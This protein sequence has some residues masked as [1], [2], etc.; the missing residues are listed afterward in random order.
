MYPFTAS[1]ELPSTRRRHVPSSSETSMC[2]GAGLRR[3]C[4]FGSS[5]SASTSGVPACVAPHGITSAISEMN[6]RTVAYRSSSCLRQAVSASSSVL[7]GSSSPSSTIALA[8][9]SRVTSC[10]IRSHAWATLSGTGSPPPSPP[11]LS[12]GT[13]RNTETASLTF[14]AAFR[15]RGS[16]FSFALS[17]SRSARASS[18]VAINVSNSVNA[19]STE[20]PSRCRIVA[21]TVAVRRGS[22]S[23]R[24]VGACALIPYRASSASFT[25]GTRHKSSSPDF[26]PWTSRVRS[27]AAFCPRPDTSRGPLRHPSST[28]RAAP[29]GTSRSSSSPRRNSGSTG[30]STTE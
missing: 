17:S 11:S 5:R 21:S 23:L 26:T 2:S 9:S 1:S 3:A 29:S 27:N 13:S 20:T 22:A 6:G 19:S 30:A 10:S 7:S 18:F 4:T 28:D 24:S 12:M 15:R 16:P 8:S 25:G 14:A